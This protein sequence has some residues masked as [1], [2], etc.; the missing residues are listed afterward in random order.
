MSITYINTKEV[1][2]LK[3]IYKL[4]YKFYNA[5]HGCIRYFSILF[6]EQYSW[7]NSIDIRGPK[8]IFAY[9][10]KIFIFHI[11]ANRN[12][13]LST[14]FQ[15][16]DKCRYYAFILHKLSTLPFIDALFDPFEIN[17][18]LIFNLRTPTNS[19]SACSVSSSDTV[20]LF[21]PIV[22]AMP[23]ESFVGPKDKCCSACDDWAAKPATEATTLEKERC[24]SVSVLFPVASLALPEMTFRFLLHLFSSITMFAC[25]L[26]IPLLPPTFLRCNFPGTSALLWFIR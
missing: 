11:Y 8:I 4:Y 19:T 18:R 9:L 24:I 22:W 6:L 16:S 13:C 1:K 12:C 7:N 5:N 17:A 14:T 26:L 25:C 15:N 20:F 3:H 2:R 23:A 21:I 10:V